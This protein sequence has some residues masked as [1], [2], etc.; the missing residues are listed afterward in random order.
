MGMVIKV[1]KFKADRRQAFGTL[2]MTE[3][4][5]GSEGLILHEAIKTD[6]NWEGVRWPNFPLLVYY[7]RSVG[8]NSLV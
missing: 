3:T 2:R 8:L 1:K 5:R 6:R 4:V 7:C